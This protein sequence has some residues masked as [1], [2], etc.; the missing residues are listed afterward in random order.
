MLLIIGLG[1]SSC[2]DA[3]EYPTKPKITFESIIFKEIGTNTDPDSL[4]MTIGFQDGDGDLGLD[5]RFTDPNFRKGDFWIDVNTGELVTLK[6]F[7]Q[8]GFEQVMPY[9]FPYS[10]EHW[11]EGSTFTNFCSLAGIPNDCD[12]RIEEFGLNTLVTEK[13]KLILDT[14]WFNPNPNRSNYFLTFLEETAPD[15]FEEF[16]WQNADIQDP[17]AI[18]FSL[19]FPPISKKEG[20]FVSEGK[21]RF[22]LTANRMPTV[23]KNKR[24]MVEIKIKDR[25]LNESNAVF[26]EAF[27]LQEIRVN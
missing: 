21:I 8:P 15:N 18:N 14:I 13:T 6:H 19:T 22:S 5:D 25:A 16:D 2:Y 3:P 26:S 11:I 1:F 10:C 23:F 27:T 4:I 9:E 7:G 12:K 20:R 17:C 24:L